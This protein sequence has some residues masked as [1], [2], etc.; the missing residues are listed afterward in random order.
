M[1]NNQ[2]SKQKVSP[3]EIGQFDGVIRFAKLNDIGQL[4]PILETWIRWEGQIIKIEVEEVLKLVAESIEGKNDNHF[5]VAETVDKEV[6]GMIGFKPPEKR[7]L[8]FSKTDKPVELINAYVA[9]KHRGGKGVGRALVNRLEQEAIKAGGEEVILNSGPRY[10]NS[11]W[12]FYDRI[13]YEN[14][15][16]ARHYY[17]AGFHAPVWRKEL[18]PS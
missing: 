15:G 2:E 14:I 11:G 13:G 10:K 4:R 17:G 18:S 12:G 8:P 7:M 9:K 6:I 5:L 1:S 16:T 3:Q